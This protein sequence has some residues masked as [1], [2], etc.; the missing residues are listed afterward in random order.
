MYLHVNIPELW[1]LWAGI[2]HEDC[3]RNMSQK[4]VGD[5]R[6]LLDY[7]NISYGFMFVD[8]HGWCSRHLCSRVHGEHG[9]RLR[10]G[11]WWHVDNESF[12]PKDRETCINTCS[13]CVTVHIC[14]ERSVCT[15]QP[16]VAKSACSSTVQHKRYYTL[17]DN[18]T[19]CS[20]QH[21]LLLHV[22]AQIHR[23]LLVYMLKGLYLCDRQDVAVDD[24]SDS[25]E[26]N[27]NRIQC[28]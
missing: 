26:R 20:E 27:L 25:L 14:R 12:T 5:G 3:E 23:C 1:L 15:F 10:T 24:F 28:H 19:V 6:F 7:T 17:Y 16:C 4:S 11:F 21:V 13:S 22:Q 9:L 18:L 2:R 8:I